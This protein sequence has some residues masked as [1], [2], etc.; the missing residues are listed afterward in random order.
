[1]GLNLM[2]NNEEAEKPGV[3][4]DPP[5]VTTLVNTARK[6]DRVAFGK[7]V[8]FFWRGIFQMV[9]Y[10]TFSRPDAED[11]TQ[12]IF[13]RAFVQLP[14]LKDTK[15]FKPW[16][17]SIAVNRVRDFLRKKRLMSIFGLSKEREAFEGFEKIESGSPSPLDAVIKKQFWT[18]VRRFSESLSGMEQQVFL[19]RFLDGLNLSEIADVLK[20]DESSIKT[21]LYRAVGKFRRKPRLL[22]VVREG[23]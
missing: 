6:G 13:I 11:L 10:R 20:K 8:D 23:I 7:L 1:M 22:Q 17:Y 9:Y 2:G 21:H 18:E 16:L 14:K 4:D 15:K 19:L 3:T 12:E 5:D